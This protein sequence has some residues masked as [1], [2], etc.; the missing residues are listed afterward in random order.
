[1]IVK[2]KQSLWGVN[3]HGGE[4]EIGILESLGAVVGEVDAVARASVDTEGVASPIATQCQV[5]DD[6]VGTEMLLHT[7][8]VVGEE[9]VGGSLQKQ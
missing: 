6:V 2:G 8:S 5:N 7:A 4:I 9:G 3:T 1:V